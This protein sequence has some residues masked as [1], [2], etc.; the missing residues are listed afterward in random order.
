MR[1]AET[2]EVVRFESSL[3]PEQQRELALR[4]KLAPSLF[5]VVERLKK[6]APPPGAEE[7][8]F[9]RDGKAEV[10]IWL[11]EKTPEVLAQLKQLGFELAL[12][13]RT[14]KPVIGRLPLE[15]LSALVDV[16]AVRFVAPQRT[17][18]GKG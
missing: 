8:K 9:V 13:P 16:K 15:K 14:A 5:A 10:Q 11:T 6:K 1:I 17:A 12:D 4:A 3:T 18:K 7:A 2:D